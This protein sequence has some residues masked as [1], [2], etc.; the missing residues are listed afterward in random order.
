MCI[1]ITS[2]ESMSIPISLPKMVFEQ[3]VTVIND[4]ARP[5]DIPDTPDTMPFFKVTQNIAI[6][7]MPQLLAVWPTGMRHWH[8]QWRNVSRSRLRYQIEEFCTT[9]NPPHARRSSDD[10]DFASLW[11]T[12]TSHSHCTWDSLFIQSTDFDSNCP[13]SM[14]CYSLSLSSGVPV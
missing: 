2:V 8:A 10:P 14:A 11:S 13:K 12:H 1:S 5:T 7:K 6:C 3:V 4:I 9:A